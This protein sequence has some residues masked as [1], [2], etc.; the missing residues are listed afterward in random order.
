MNIQLTFKCPDAVDYAIEDIPE[1]D[2]AEVAHLLKRW[3]EYGEVITVEVD[4]E[5]KTI[6]V[7][8]VN[9]FR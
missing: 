8:P 9:I 3:I 6:Q 1:E 2:R 7:I 5:T 4:T